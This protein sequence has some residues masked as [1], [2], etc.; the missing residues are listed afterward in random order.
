MKKK[1]FPILLASSLLFSVAPIVDHHEAQAKHKGSTV[2]INNQ[3]YIYQGRVSK[4]YP[5]GYCKLVNKYAK[6]SQSFT[7]FVSGTSGFAA[8]AKKSGYAGVLSSSLYVANLG[9]QNNTKV[10]KTAAKKGT[11]VTISY[12][13]YVPKTGGNYS[14]ARNSKVSYR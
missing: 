8:A 3:K 4:H 11:G 10:Y 9:V 6:K 1:I 7:N 13:L 2:T 5:K 14:L 12:D